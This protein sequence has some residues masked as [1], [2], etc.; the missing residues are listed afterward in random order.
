VSRR[1]RIAIVLAGLIVFAG[2][3]LVITLLLVPGQN[4]RTE[5]LRLVRTQA[6]GDASGMLA[7]LAGC[8]ARPACLADARVDAATLRQPGAV[9]LLSFQPSSTI[10][11]GSTRGVARVVWR[12]GSRAP[13]VQCVQVGRGSGLFGARRVTLLAVSR[14]IASNG[15][16]S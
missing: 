9:E 12:T 14:Q 8:S 2:A 1:R 7:Q 6:R 4:E 13:V 5:V 3:S 11:L 16:C 15:S 10:A